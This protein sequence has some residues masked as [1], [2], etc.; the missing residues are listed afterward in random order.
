MGA[1]RIDNLERALFILRLRVAK[2]KQLLAQPME[3]HCARGARRTLEKMCDDVRRLLALRDALM[4]IDP[5]D[6]VH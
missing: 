4:T 1:D 6:L 5:P 2:Q 3:E